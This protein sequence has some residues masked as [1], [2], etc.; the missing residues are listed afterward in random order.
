MKELV[1]RQSMRLSLA[2]L[3]ASPFCN[4]DCKYC[5]LPN[6]SSVH[7]MSNEVLEQSLRFLMREKPGLLD[8]DANLI[9]HCGEPLSVP[10]DFYRRAFDS[11]EKMNTGPSAIPVRFSTNGTLIDQ[12]WCDLIN[13]R[14]YIRMRVSID[15]P[16]WL[17]D[18]NRVTR[19]QRGTFPEVM[20][21]INLLRSNGIPFDVLCV[22]TREALQVPEELWAFLSNLGA[23]GVGFCIEEVLGEHKASSLE[24]AASCEQVRNFFRV[25]MK[26]RD[27]EAPELYVREVDQ[28]LEWIP[29]RYKQKGFFV[30]SDNVP[31]SLITISWDGNICLF[32][33][34]LLN[35]TSPYYGDFVFGN[36]ATHSV[37]DI[38]ASSK[39]QAAYRQIYH[40][41]RQCGRECKYFPTCGGGFP[42][43]KLL[44]NGTFRST[45][46]LTCR[47]RVQAITDVVM[48][49]LGS[50]AT[51]L[52]ID[53]S[54]TA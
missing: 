5:Y 37:E 36:V 14:G 23:K 17:H 15:G 43:N 12:E 47:L 27:K 1:D 8:D 11:L 16:Q 42:V 4:I 39:F 41:V 21:G 45:E 13:E 19:Q 28:L 51:Q 22:L 20:R 3:Q 30:R 53:A 6:R 49:H 31:F 40:G 9:F 32:S 38:L 10:I 26:L 44:E 33:P 18:S 2:L 46:T 24:F 34:E 7:R 35:A 48:E 29:Q 50:D 52:A 25:W 54:T